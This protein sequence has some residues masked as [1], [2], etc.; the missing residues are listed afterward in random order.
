MAFM[1]SIAAMQVAVDIYK[2]LPGAAGG[3]SGPPWGS[4]P[5]RLPLTAGG[6]GVGAGAAVASKAAA[7]TDNVRPQVLADLYGYR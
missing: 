4:L 3:N 1:F 6:L 7:A 2:I 5:W